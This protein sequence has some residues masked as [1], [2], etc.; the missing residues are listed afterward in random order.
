[1]DN[2]HRERLLC[3]INASL[4]LKRVIPELEALIEWRG[5]PQIIPVDHGPEFISHHSKD[6]I[7][8]SL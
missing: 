8:F 2:H 1:M 4:K 6:E 7:H 5:K 3:R